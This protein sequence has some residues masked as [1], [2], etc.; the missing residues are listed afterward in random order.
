MP[1]FAAN[2]SFLFQEVEF[3]DRF[4]AAARAG[5]RG[6]EYLFPYD[7]AAEALA[8]RLK[9]FDLKQVL[10]NLPPGAW[11]A[12]ERGM[13]ALPGREAAFEESVEQALA[14]ARMLECGQVHAMAGIP[15]AE[16]PREICEAVYIR[17]LSLAADKLKRHGIRLLIEPL[18]SRDV[19]GYFLNTVGQAR[20]IIEQAGS[21][22]LFLQMDLYHCQIVE[23]DLAEK[24]KASFGV[25]RHFQ[26]AGVPGRHEP[27]V[28]EINY[29][30]LF[31]LMDELGYTGWVGCEYRPKAGTVAGLGWA[32]RYGVRPGPDAV[33]PDP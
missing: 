6:V 8:E 18:N 29:Q 4:K 24:I 30:Y 13:A 5:F 2:L 21:D 32:R 26:V 20:R 10:F 27:D 23:G 7:F 9:A 33:A 17:N 15:P 28:G 11:A 19:P 14:Y 16:A 12:G 1:T 31:D 3:L 22:N 25:I